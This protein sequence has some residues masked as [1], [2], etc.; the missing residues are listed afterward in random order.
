MTITSNF[1]TILR[2][3]QDQ[4]KRFTDKKVKRSFWYNFYSAGHQIG[5]WMMSENTGKSAKNA[6]KMVF[7]SK[8]VSKNGA[9]EQRGRKNDEGDGRDDMKKEGG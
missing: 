3:R 2:W 6:Q 7:V 9:P 8:Y 4:K 1:T 5:A